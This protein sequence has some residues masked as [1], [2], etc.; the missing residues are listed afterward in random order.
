MSWFLFY[1]FLPF[2]LYAFSLS[3][4][5]FQS[6]EANIQMMKTEYYHGDAL[7][8]K[9]FVNRK[10][11]FPLLFMII[12]VCLEDK[13]SL[14]IH[15][16]QLKTL[17]FPGFQNNI[18]LEFKMDSLLRGEYVF[19]GIRMK[20]GDLL[21]L[22]E[23]EKLVEIEK[24]LIVYPVYEE[25]IYRPMESHYDQGMAAT[26]GRV[27]RDSSMAIGIREY[28][29]GDRFSWIN[30][31]ATAK[32]NDIMTKEFEQRQSHDVNIVM[33]CAPDSHFETIVSFTASIVRGILRKG[34]NV[35][36]MTASNERSLFPIRGGEQQQQ[37]I[38]YHLAKVKDQSPRT[39]DRI[40]DTE[41]ILIQ[42]KTTLILVTAKLT[43][44]LI[45]KV[46]FLS[47]KSPV[48]V[49]LMKQ[50][51][52]AATQNEI[53]LIAQARA[54]GMI[55]KYVYRGYFAEAFSEVRRK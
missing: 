11:R 55:V 5:S 53:S 9:V 39:L 33:D 52:E 7:K 6:L 29:P 24:K 51:N 25:I 20:T 3:I 13:Q 22:I 23:K 30:W 2:A 10:S 34:A 31:K 48:Y 35:G 21:G 14:S 37:K 54:G 38:F 47:R 8:L 26:R 49:F 4:Y 16:T 44:A 42:E 41:M 43:K 18:S 17:V 50:D 19:K 15:S 27:Q 1:S 36:L 12:E 45:G 28:Q 32:R 40:L 46:G